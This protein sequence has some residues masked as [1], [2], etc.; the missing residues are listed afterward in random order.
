KLM[1]D[2]LDYMT[3]DGPLV[4]ACRLIV[5][6]LLQTGRPAGSRP[7]N[8]QNGTQPRRQSISK[9]LGQLKEEFF[10]LAAECDRNKAGLSL[11]NLL[12]ELFELFELRP[13]QPF[14]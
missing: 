1:S 6:R 12:N 7:A 5:C 10:R 2:M 11:E 9:E 14:R 4:E 13:R 3:A 8:T